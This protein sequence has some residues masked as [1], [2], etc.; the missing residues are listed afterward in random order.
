MSATRRGIRPVLLRVALPA[1]L[2]AGLLL[3]AGAPRAAAQGSLK[4]AYLQRFVG[5]PAPPFLLKDLEGREVRLS[6]HKGKV[7]LL[8]YW[9]TGCFPCRQE[10]PDLIRLYN[11]HKA[12]GLVIL[13]INLDAILM[14]ADDRRMLQRFVQDF[15]IPY[16]TLIAEDK[17]Y[18]D[19]GKPSIAPLT[20]LI[21]RQGRIA[22]VFWGAYSF[23]VYE[24]AVRP[25]LEASGP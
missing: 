9:Y 22:Q 10:T 16:P 13:G 3:L 20:L 7:I 11:A 17:M 24:N 1:C 15:E 8:N 6:D 12:R 5:R 2:A 18:D 14:P 25:Y 4:E 21:D 19:Y 23:S